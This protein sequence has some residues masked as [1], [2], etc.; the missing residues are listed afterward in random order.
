VVTV[1]VAVVTALLPTY[2]PPRM[3]VDP[4][5][6]MIQ[7]PPALVGLQLP[8]VLRV[9]EVDYEYFRSQE[10]TPGEEAIRVAVASSRQQQVLAW[11]TPPALEGSVVVSV[12][13]DVVARHPA[14]AFDRGVLLSAGRS[15]LVVVRATRPDVS[16]RVGVAVYQWPS[17]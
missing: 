6:D 11:V 16:V 4:A 8:P 14:G 9:G 17:S 13:G 3:V 12:D 5:P 15:H 1:L 10:S 2:A 7:P